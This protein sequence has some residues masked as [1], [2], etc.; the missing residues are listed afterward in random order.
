MDR[1][2]IWRCGLIMNGS[3]VLDVLY[4]GDRCLHCNRWGMC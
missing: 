1:D 4:G 2:D 3:G